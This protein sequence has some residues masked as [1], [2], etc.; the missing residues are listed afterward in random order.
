MAA[1]YVN[2]NA[3]L[4]VSRNTLLPRFDLI[5]MCGWCTE[6]NRDLTNV[7]DFLHA[8]GMRHKF[9][10]EDTCYFPLDV[11]IANSKCDHIWSQNTPESRCPLMLFYTC[12][13]GSESNE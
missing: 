3:A 4:T 10:S 1:D 9:W 13:T 5:V 2:K 8:V 7:V 6:S 12:L 11:S